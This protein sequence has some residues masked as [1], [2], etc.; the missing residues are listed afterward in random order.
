MM[1]TALGRIRGRQ[2]AIVTALAGGVLAAS[3]VGAAPAVSFLSSPN[4]WD[5]QLPGT[6]TLLARGAAVRVPVD[7]SCPAGF[8]ATLSVALTQRSGPSVV[9]GSDSVEL[10]CRGVPQTVQ[11]TVPAQ[12]GQRTWKRGP[13]LATATLGACDFYFCGT[14]ARDSE[15]IR[16]SR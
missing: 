7:V 16:I 14:L 3:V 8:R 11:V 2:A 6:G 10:T 4:T 15:E 13:A 1:R 5:V 12:P 9:T